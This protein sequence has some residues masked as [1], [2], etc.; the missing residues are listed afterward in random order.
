[1]QIEHPGPAPA[2]WPCIPRSTHALSAETSLQI[3]FEQKGL[4][5][6]SKRIHPV[7]KVDLELVTPNFLQ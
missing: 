2:A 3:C 6:I 5:R 1:M 7:D 4:T